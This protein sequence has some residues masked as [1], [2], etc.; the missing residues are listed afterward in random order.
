MNK[1]GNLTAGAAIPK[2]GLVDSLLWRFRKG[3]WSLLG[4]FKFRG[5]KPAVFP[6]P[7]G[8]DRRIAPIPLAA[9]APG[10]PI[11]DILV[12][13][14]VPPDEAQPLKKLFYRF[15]LLM[16]RL[17]P[18]MQARLPPVS[19]DQDKA[20]QE[21]YSQGHRALFPA[22]QRPAEL[23][24]EGGADLA[25]LA[26]KGP[27]ACYLERDSEGGFQ[28]DFLDL[29]G[30]ELH[31]GLYPFG[32]KVLFGVDTAKG[33]LRAERITSAHPTR[34]GVPRAGSRSAQRRRICRSCGILIGCIWRRAAPWPSPRPR[35]GRTVL[36]G[37]Q[38]VFGSAARAPGLRRRYIQYDGSGA[39]WIGT[40]LTS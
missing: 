27:F 23:S 24:R 34:S 7:I 8:G 39:A 28:W 1:Q 11:E 38:T 10:I 16:Y 35:Y 12:A 3:F 9:V 30:Y 22:P 36:E 29:G 15:Q 33:A 20:P 26:V 40:I 14:R 37:K 17:L 2:L 13:D 5:N 4:L 31:D 18:A 21:A 19:D 25:G 32:V 6:V